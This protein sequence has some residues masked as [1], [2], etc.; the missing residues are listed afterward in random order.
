MFN[1]R[2]R[3]ALVTGCGSA[4]GIGFA[5]ARLLNRLG[6]AV[7]ITA[8]S[9]RVY[10]RAQELNHEAQEGNMVPVTS[11]TADLSIPEQAR[12]L[13]S[14]V[15]SNH[16]RIDVLV[17]AAGNARIG[18]PAP[19]ARFASLTAEEWRQDLDVNLMTAVYTTQA[20]VSGM[21]KRHYGRIVMI[22]SVTGPLV[23]A[24]EQSG[25]AAA[26]SALDGVMRSIALEYGRSGITCNSVAPGWIATDA[27]TTDGSKAGRA[28]PIGRPG[29]PGEVA[30]AVAFLA[31]DEAAY[32]TGQMI[33]VDGG[34]VIQEAHGVDLYA[35]GERTNGS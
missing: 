30:A 18:M 6:A 29:T 11:H 2:D 4:T 27:L 15:E 33:V 5:S 7:A 12:E 21:E 19:S 13:V 26:K 32:V 20:V 10:Q 25:Y 17:N 31:S 9:E 14:T 28:T 22:S 23:T 24:P 3:V 8:T 34:N 35:E 1:F 16:G